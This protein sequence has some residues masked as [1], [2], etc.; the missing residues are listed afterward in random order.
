MLVRIKVYVEGMLCQWLWL[1]LPVLYP[2]NETRAGAEAELGRNNDSPELIFQKKSFST[3]S[4]SYVGITNMKKDVSIGWESKT[5]RPWQGSHVFAPAP[6]S[7]LSSEKL[8]GV[9]LNACP[10]KDIWV[11]M[12]RMHLF[13]KGCT[14]L[15]KEGK[16]GA[17]NLYLSLAQI[18]GAAGTS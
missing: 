8:E 5:L 17:D 4:Y 11:S 9:P 14:F 7:G 3:N 1:L 13:K 18:P 2:Q 6:Q 15:G 12:T 10:G 16:E